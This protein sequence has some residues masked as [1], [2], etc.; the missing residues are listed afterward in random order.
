M[1]SDGIVMT[2]LFQIVIVYLLLLL[3]TFAVPKL[4]PL[5]YTALFFLVFFI[6]FTTVI[7]PFSKSFLALFDALSNPFASLLLGSAIIYMISEVIT[8]HISDAGYP[9][10]AE[11]AHFSMKITILMLWMNE[12]KEVIALLSTLITTWWDMYKYDSF[13]EYNTRSSNFKLYTR[14]FIVFYG[15]I[16][17]FS[18]SFI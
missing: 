18:F 9:S 5:L 12:I 6:V 1:V 16:N 8:G 15:A 4:Q 14:Y 10:L 2:T 11:L 3:I 13:S 7:L 17:W